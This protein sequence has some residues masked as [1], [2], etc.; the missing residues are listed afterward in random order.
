MR[1]YRTIDDYWWF[2]K[3]SSMIDRTDYA[4][5]VFQENAFSSHSGYCT[6]RAKDS[7]NRVG[8]YIKVRN[9]FYVATEEPSYYK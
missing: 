9:N 1:E 6:I 8:K 2:I 4:F 3:G 5:C 7:I